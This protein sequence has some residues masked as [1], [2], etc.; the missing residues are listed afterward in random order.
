MQIVIRAVM[1]EVEAVQCAVVSRNDREAYFSKF[2]QWRTTAIIFF[3]LIER[4]EYVIGR[5]W[6]S[7]EICDL[8][9][10]FFFFFFF[11]GF[12]RLASLARANFLYCECV[13]KRVVK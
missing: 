12:V 4:F 5:L 2:V 6:F 7:A 8:I 10:F 3:K 11:F 13:I 9:S 1:Y